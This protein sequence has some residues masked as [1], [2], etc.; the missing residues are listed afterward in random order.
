MIFQGKVDVVF[1]VFDGNNEVKFSLSKV[2]IAASG[3][4]LAATKVRGNI[5]D[6]TGKEHVSGGLCGSD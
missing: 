3:G 6:M 5:I 4:Q 2:D 1:T